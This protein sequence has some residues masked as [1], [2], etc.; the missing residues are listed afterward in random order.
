M[1]GQHD[2]ILSELNEEDDPAREE[3][4]KTYASHFLIVLMYFRIDRS[5]QIIMRTAERYFRENNAEKGRE[6]V[7]SLEVSLLFLMFLY[8]LF[9]KFKIGCLSFMALHNVLLEKDR[10]VGGFTET[11]ER[12]VPAYLM[13]VD[14]GNLITLLILLVSFYR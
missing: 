11:I 14:A 10:V 3:N 12:Y 1:A 8:H 6:V 7:E 13:R 2:L 5:V 9:Q 4:L